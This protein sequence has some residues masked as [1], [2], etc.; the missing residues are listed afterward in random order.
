VNARYRVQ[1]SLVLALLAAPAGGAC[2]PERDAGPAP[3]APG[4]T[5]F[6]STREASVVTICG[7]EEPGRRLAVT[8][9]VLDYDGR[10]LSGA[11]VIA[12]HTGEDGIYNPRTS[13]TR[14]PRLRGTAV[15]AGDGTFTF[16][17]IWPGAYPEG[18]APAHIHLIVTAPAH[19]PRFLEIQFEGDPQLTREHRD[20]AERTGN[21]IIVKPTKGAD[22]AWSFHQ[23]VRLSG[24]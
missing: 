9:R 19:H 18:G 3:R 2:A 4:A 16:H 22:G 24:S 14:V 10:P 5:T 6:G 11:A 8:G 13:A 15:T 23:D 1:A 21:A 20:H 12:Y 7:P 17:T